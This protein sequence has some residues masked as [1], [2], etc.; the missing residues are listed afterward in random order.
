MTGWEGKEFVDDSEN[1]KSATE[2]AE[3]GD[4]PWGVV[5]PI[6]IDA[7][8]IWTK[9]GASSENDPHVYCRMS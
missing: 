4:S 3:H 5:E 2:I 7:K 8:W 9:E 6:S 1:W